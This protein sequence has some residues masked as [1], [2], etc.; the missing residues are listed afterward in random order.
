MSRLRP[1][2]KLFSRLLSIVVLVA[3]G[4]QTAIAKGPSGAGINPTRIV[5]P[6]NR[7]S[8]S[9]TLTNTSDVEV[10]YRM[11]LVEMGLDKNGVFRR[12]NTNELHRNQKSA[13][14]FVRFSPRQVRLKPGASQIV[15]A[16]ARR[17]RMETGEY[18]SH[19]FLRALPV[20]EDLANNNSDEYAVLVESS[21]SVDVGVTIPVIVRHNNTDA[22]VA[23]TTATVQFDNEGKANAIDLLLALTGNRSTFGDITVSMVNGSKDEVIARLNS[24]ALYYPY[25][26]ENVRLHIQKGYNKSN[27]DENTRLNVVFRNKSED[28]DR[29]HWLNESIAPVLQ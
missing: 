28:S 5:I 12:L 7:S 8:A 19:L 10:A 26:Q 17:A 23:L 18:R 14:P 6:A 1:L 25:P 9:V 20:L 16:I 11:E 2:F 3:L 15:R 27:F 13:K 4:F 22:T 24:F 21:S 29:T